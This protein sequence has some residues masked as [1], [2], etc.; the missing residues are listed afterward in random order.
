MMSRDDPGVLCQWCRW[1]DEYVPDDAGNDADRG[2]CRL[3]APL[4][5]DGDGL[6]MW[7]VTDQVDWC[8]EFDLSVDALRE[9]G[10]EV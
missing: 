8:G 9:Q 6:A 7:P 5:L 3:H 4:D 2:E 10:G 1:W